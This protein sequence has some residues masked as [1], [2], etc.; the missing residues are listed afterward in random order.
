MSLSFWNENV[1]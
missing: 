1:S